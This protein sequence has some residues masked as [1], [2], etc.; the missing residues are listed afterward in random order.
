MNETHQT[1]GL[2]MERG[3]TPLQASPASTT[4]I[5]W[6]HRLASFFQYISLWLNISVPTCY[7]S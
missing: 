2:E 5:P 3:L 6:E 4:Q 1:S 7:A